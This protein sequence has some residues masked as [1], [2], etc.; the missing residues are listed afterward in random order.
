MRRMLCTAAIAA[1]VIGAH[2]M[3]AAASQLVIMA[4]EAG[5][6]GGT[7]TDKNKAATVRFSTVS[8]NNKEVMR[9]GETK[10]LH[11]DERAEK[12]QERLEMVLKPEAGQKYRPV[13]ASDVTVES[14]GP[15]VVVR[16][17]NLNVAQATPEDAKL[18]GMSTQAL[19]QQWAQS[20]RSALQDV[21]VGQNGQLPDNFIAIANGQMT[22]QGGGAGGTPPKNDKKD[23]D[24]K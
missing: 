9:L 8:V 4:A 12:V 17:R 6:G 2:A 3:P 16:L 13:Q 11:A 21:K 24:M 18:A 23:Q 10:D 19:A 7:A 20:L 5:G 14:V 15:A 22:P 1:A